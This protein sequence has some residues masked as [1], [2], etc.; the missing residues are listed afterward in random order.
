MVGR[1][2]GRQRP[3][4]NESEKTGNRKPNG[5]E[6]KRS[7]TPVIDYYTKFDGGRAVFIRTIL[8]GV[9]DAGGPVKW[10][11]VIQETIDFCGD[12]GM[13]PDDNMVKRFC[14]DARWSN[15]MIS[16]E[17]VGTDR[18]YT[19]TLTE[20]PKFL[21]Q[22]DKLLGTDWGLIEDDNGE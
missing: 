20:D 5:Y 1:S 15:R 19:A 18:G 4:R 13:Y 2:T 14:M 3:R 22:L 11:E 17:R 6:L 12:F 21:S 9:R 7:V 10:K 8:E 16:L